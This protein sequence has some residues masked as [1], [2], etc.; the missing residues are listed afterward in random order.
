MAGPKHLSLPP[1]SVTG[2][3]MTQAQRA[4]LKR[5]ALLNN[6]TNGQLISARL[7]GEE[8]PMVEVDS[9]DGGKMVQAT[10]NI[11][12]EDQKA[13]EQKSSRL[14]MSDSS[15]VRALLFGN[16]EADQGRARLQDS[17][18]YDCVMTIGQREALKQTMALYPEFSSYG[19]LLMAVVEG[20]DLDVVRPTGSPEETERIKVKF[21][22]SGQELVMLEGQAELEGL[23]RPDF[24]RLSMF[25]ESYL[26]WLKTSAE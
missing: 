14:K 25:G 18:V 23:K 22:L 11:S 13:I 6:M 20:V 17:R 9:T 2:Y 4:A 15:Y 8:V 3:S 12:P 16:C 5:S 1:R 7:K 19:R 24:I 21:V 26:P 10:V